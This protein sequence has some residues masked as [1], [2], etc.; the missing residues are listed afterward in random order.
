[1]WRPPAS[2]WP[3]QAPFAPVFG[4]VPRLVPASRVAFRCGEFG[5]SVA[6]AKMKGPARGRHLRTRTVGSTVAGP[7]VDTLVPI[8][9][10]FGGTLSPQ[11]VRNPVL[12]GYFGKV[13]CEVLAAPLTYAV[14]NSLKRQEG[15]G[16]LDEGISFNPSGGSLAADTAG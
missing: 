7:G 5:N 9:L 11:P 1:M 4:F 2:G 15:T 3:H 12:S 8:A 14:V 13:A 16:P 10:A 6:M